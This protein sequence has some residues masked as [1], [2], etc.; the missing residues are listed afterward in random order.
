MRNPLDRPKR[1][2]ARAWNLPPNSTFIALPHAVIAA[3][4]GAGLT[5][6]HIVTMLAIAD[7]WR[8]EA[9]S[10]FH[11]SIRDL[12]ES[13]GRPKSNIDRDLRDLQKAGIIT[14]ERAH[15]KPLKID[16][17]PILRAL[18]PKEK[19]SHPRDNQLSHPRDTTV[20]LLSHP[21][22]NHSQPQNGTQLQTGQG[23]ATVPPMGQLQPR[24]RQTP[25]TREKEVASLGPDQMKANG[26]GQGK[27]PAELAAVKA[28]LEALTAPKRH[29]RAIDGET[30]ADTQKRLAAEM[31]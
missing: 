20:P 11:T 9:G 19:M 3:I 15:G 30:Y 10:S 26:N 27:S 29:P 8:P 31:G 12:G 4:N 2:V 14:M 18:A 25:D 28:A 22:D 17:A 7:A 5:D 24:N 6:R 13:V 1:N 21:W 23:L 16:L